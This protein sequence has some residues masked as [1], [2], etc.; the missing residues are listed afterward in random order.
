M[1]E[2]ALASVASAW[3]RNATPAGLV[4][5]DV[6]YFKQVNDQHGH[7]VGDE[8]LRAAGA[9]IRACCRPYDTPCRFGGDEFAVVLNH[10][11]G[12][13][14][15]R[16][17]TRLRESLAQVRVRAGDTA[18][19]LSTS[20]GLATTTGMPSRFRTEELMRRADE[21]LYAAKNAGRGRL[22]VAPPP[23]D[24]D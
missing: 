16:A 5:I 17:A 18:L 24:A 14:A 19:D 10:V 8:L 21:A 3:D 11:E 15:L 1:L 22:E 12:E 20:A 9:A 4:L 6:D 7:G 23:S 2:D 13:N